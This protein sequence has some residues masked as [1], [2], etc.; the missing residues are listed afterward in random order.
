MFQRDPSTYICTYVGFSVSRYLL[1]SSWYNAETVTCRPHKASEVFVTGTFDDWGKT[2]K[3]DRVGDIFVK[4]VTISP[5]QK[6]HYKV[7]AY[8]FI[9]SHLL[10][11][12]DLFPS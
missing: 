8:N 7:W 2:V 4:E 6:I 11:P 9:F 1:N 10:L 12:L 5:V 3:M